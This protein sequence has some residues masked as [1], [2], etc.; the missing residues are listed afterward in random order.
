VSTFTI[1]L[2]QLA[3]KMQA[4]L[5]T[6][7]QRSTLEVFRSVVQKSPVD[8]GRFRANWN[9][10]HGTPD[11]HTTQSVDQG[12]GIAEASKAATFAV[13]GVIYLTNGLP[14]AV[15]LEYGYSK[16]A[17]S[18]MVR[19]SAAEFQDHVAKAIAKT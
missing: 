6:V 17:P 5:E 7:V 13:G 15:R 12:R 8:T 19:L 11:A 14:Y 4:D 18:G 3:E 9:A 16:Q 10:S 1:P 2:A